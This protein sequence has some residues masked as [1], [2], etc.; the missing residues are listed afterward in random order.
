MREMP[1]TDQ[2]IYQTWAG[3]FLAIRVSGIFCIFCGLLCA[4]VG[5]ILI[6]QADFVSDYI[7]A[8]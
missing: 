2:M 6:F 4:H 5:L 7:C 1:L 3:R 8:P